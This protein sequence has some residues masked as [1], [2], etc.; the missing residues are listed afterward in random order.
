MPVASLSAILLVT[1]AALRQPC[2][3][4][5]TCTAMRALLSQP[6]PPSCGVV[7]VLY[8]VMARQRCQLDCPNNQFAAA[9]A[10]QRWLPQPQTA[11]CKAADTLVTAKGQSRII[12]KDEV[13]EHN[14]METGVWVTH[15]ARHR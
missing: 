8:Q 11:H 10:A 15:K 6:Q 14:S 7:L 1:V 2:T 5:H 12:S 3:V 9:Q 13:A 4:S